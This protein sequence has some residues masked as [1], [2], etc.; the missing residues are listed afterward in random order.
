MIIQPRHL[1]R[2]LDGRAG[3]QISIAFLPGA[4]G[5]HIHTLQTTVSLRLEYARKLLKHGVRYEGFF[6][7]QD[8]IDSGMCMIEDDHH[9]RFLY[10]K[11]NIHPEIYFLLLKTDKSR[12]EL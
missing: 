5:G 11:D 7:I 1:V 4:L 12:R 8:T 2:F 6:H 3:D 10:V 9:L